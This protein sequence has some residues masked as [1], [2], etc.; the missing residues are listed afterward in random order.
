MIVSQSKFFERVWGNF[1]SQKFPQFV[2][3]WILFISLFVGFSFSN[4]ASAE[5]PPK[6]ITVTVIPFAARAGE[7]Q[8]WLS[9]GL[10]DIFIRHL[11]EI[12]SL[13]VLE[14]DHIQA[15]VNELELGDAPLFDQAQALR[16]GR[17]AKVKQVLFGN[18]ELRGYRLVFAV[19]WL[20]LDTQAVLATEEA[21]GPLDQMV[22]LVRQ[23]TERLLAKR[24]TPL[25]A[26]DRSR[27]N[28][29]I[30]D[31]VSALE[32]F[33]RGIDAY[34]RGSYA[35]A[36]GQ[37][38]AAT[39][40]D[41]E[42]LDAHLWIGRMFEARG[43]NDHA[44]LT[45]R[46]LH[47][48]Y[49]QALQSLDGLY[50]AGRLLKEQLNQPEQALIE[51]KALTQSAPDSPEGIEAY[52]QI[53]QLLSEKKDFLGAYRAFHSIERFTDLTREKQ[54]F[55]TRYPKSPFFSWDHALGLF[56]DALTQAILIYARLV[57]LPEGKDIKPPRGVFILDPKRPVLEEAFGKTQSFFHNPNATH[58]WREET[59][60]VIMPP[61]YV[62]TG[63]TMELTGRLLTN[64]TCRDFTMRIYPFPIPRDPQ[65]GWIGVLYG[66]TQQIQTLRKSISFHGE[67]RQI[68]SVQLIESQGDIQH[69]KLEVQ[70]KPVTEAEMFSVPL[71]NHGS[72]FWEGQI[73]G[74]LSLPEET[75]TGATR[76]LTQ[77]FY[78]PQRDL[79]V[80]TDRTGLLH[81]V[82]TVGALDGADV[83]LW[84]ARQ[85]KNGEW[86]ALERLSVNSRGM[87]WSPR[88][89]RG[90]DGLLRL[91]W[92]SN[93]R[94]GQGWELWMSQLSK[95]GTWAS[96]WR[97][98]L[99]K[100]AIPESHPS[101]DI[102]QLLDYDL[103]QDR[104]GR[105]LIPFY[106][107][108]E[109][110]MVILTS[111]DL[112][113]WSIF[114][115]FP[116]PG[117]L[118]GF[119]VTQ[120]R[121]ERYIL[122]G[123]SETGELHLWVSNNGK[124]WE[125]HSVVGWNQ[126]YSSA[127]RF[128]MLPGP[129]GKILCLTS[130]KHIGPNIS[131]WMPPEGIATS[132]VPMVRTRLESLSSTSLLNDSY[133]VALRKDDRILVRKYKDFVPSA[134]D[135]KSEYDNFVMREIESDVEGNVWIR[136]FPGSKFIVPDVTAVGVEPPRRGES[137]P[138]VWFGIETGVFFHQGKKF[139][140]TDVTQGFFDHFVTDIQSCPGLPVFFSSRERS[141][142][143]LGMAID[144]GSS[145][146]FE[147]QT[148]PGAR[149]SIIGLACGEKPGTILVDTSTGETWEG[150]GDSWMPANPEEGPS[151]KRKALI[152]QIKNPV[153][154]AIG[155]IAKDPVNG[156]WYLPADDIPCRGV[157]Y[158]NG[159]IGKIYNPPHDVLSKPSSLA[160]DSQ[161]GVWIGTWFNGLYKLE[162]RRE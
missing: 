139:Q 11:A 104:R 53:G 31:S 18:Y 65:Q 114:S 80:A 86:T 156:V 89:F 83:D 6:P 148:I 23:T 59:Y 116:S 144:D 85:S 39:Q 29:H 108:T 131:W 49:P 72:E 60:A 134:G 27:L 84:W 110:R 107:A 24:G 90:E 52:Y 16:L 43:D 112:R 135:R 118:R 150:N 58:D 64:S 76:D 19:Y 48:A 32:H 54:D 126:K 123:W 75:H 37:F 78:Q 121:T 4:H 79:A 152:A 66:Q 160:V 138:R 2:R 102:Q 127:H 3:L 101:N 82:T 20:D 141:D 30:T 100:F 77:A 51:F 1:C 140:K 70:L 157:V 143:L 34:D 26:A 115:S 94:G 113:E 133:V 96:D 73:L 91:A 151:T 105:W 130:N 68:F 159:K 149:G 33:Y 46:S 111:R 5:P 122:G 99:E 50:F 103:F 92:I 136:A 158:D 9:K 106:S 10:S 125:D 13:A 162:R 40:Q 44:V 153:Y 67:N 155:A 161:G 95:E 42:Y 69:W 81:L 142:C 71:P 57:S 74:E 128:E 154:K 17:I 145:H 93:R 38:F 12:P 119:S 35:D 45:Y 61:G 63:V 56:P 146:R 47:K 8:A 88:L 109:D 124:I 28:I 98:P 129:D 25:T 132:K 97:V 7:S 120:D 137:D 14:R 147:T 117:R 55:R 21:S 22:S 36:W 41:E 87:D 62:A 15:F